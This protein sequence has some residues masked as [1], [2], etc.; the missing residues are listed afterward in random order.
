M[1]EEARAKIVADILSQT[2]GARALLTVL[3]NELPPAVLQQLLAEF[4]AD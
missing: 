3:A 4:K 1:D 2:G